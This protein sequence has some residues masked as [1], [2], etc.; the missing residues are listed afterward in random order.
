MATGLN[1][2]DV[3]TT[4]ATDDV[5]RRE[6]LRRAGTY[7]AVTPPLIATMLAVTSTPA[8]ANG[9]G[10]KGGRGRKPGKGNGKPR[11]GKRADGPKC[12]YPW[13]KECSD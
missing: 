10:S 6:F 2:F 3:E 9:S 11:G 5:P 1:D 4:D 7:A 12:E 13:Q 8:L